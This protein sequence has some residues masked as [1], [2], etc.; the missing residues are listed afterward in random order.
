M[1]STQNQLFENRIIKYLSENLSLII[2]IPA[3][4][5]GIRQFL[6]LSI[7]SPSLLI[8]FSTSQVLLD[9]IS[10]LFQLSIMLFTVFY[11]NKFVDKY[12]SHPLK[13]LFG[14]GSLL[15]ICYLFLRNYYNFSAISY[16]DIFLKT[17]FLILA[18]MF[19]I[20]IIKLMSASA[21]PMAFGLLL[22]IVVVIFLTYS[23]P[24]NVFNITHDNKIQSLKKQFPNI[25]LEY[26][27]DTY[28]IYNLNSKEND[29]N[30]KIYFIQ[31][32]ENLF[33]N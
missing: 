17:V 10:I 19:C 22:T 33:E 3:L 2:I 8:Y 9:G 21:L 26:V 24:L 23:K 27:N 12:K 16:S 14:I 7:L 4:L 31:K 11:F 5:G 30:K 32:H 25:K 15:I 28:L 13:I 18:T 29:K 1:A 20:Y 6:L